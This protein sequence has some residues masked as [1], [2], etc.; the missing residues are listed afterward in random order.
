MRAAVAELKGHVDFRLRNPLTSAVGQDAG[1][2][3]ALTAFTSEL[4]KLEQV[5][6]PGSAIQA[7]ASFEDG[8]A[9]ILAT[10]AAYKRRRFVTQLE[11][12]RARAVAHR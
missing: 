9:P 5:L 1:L 6:R 11:D 12:Y 7:S 8:L 4:D 2:P 10:V 3:Q